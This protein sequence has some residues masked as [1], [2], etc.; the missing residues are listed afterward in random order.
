VGVLNEWIKET[1]PQP[2]AA[3]IPEDTLI[4]ITFHQEINRNTLNTRNILILDGNNGGR[5]ISSRFLF[6]YESDSRTL[7]IYSK[8]EFEQLGARNTIEIILTGRIANIRNV[9]MEVPYHLRFTT[10]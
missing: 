7:F 8:D 4:T 3:D 6:R 10:R 9:R 5:L 1:H 2:E